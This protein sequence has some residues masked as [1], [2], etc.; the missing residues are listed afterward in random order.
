MGWFHLEPSWLQL[1]P[2]S[3]QVTPIVL[4][5]T[6]NHLSSKTPP[7]E[8]WSVYLL[9]VRS[10]FVLLPRRLKEDHAFNPAAIAIGC[11][12]DCTRLADFFAGGSAASLAGV[13]RI[14]R[15]DKA[16]FAC[17]VFKKS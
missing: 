17:G 6:R 5:S 7:Y 16:C 1:E 14:R 15:V 13:L 8:G 3:P 4:G 9:Q 2:H 11:T 12:D 10:T